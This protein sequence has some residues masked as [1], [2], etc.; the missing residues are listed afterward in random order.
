[1]ETLAAESRYLENQVAYARP[2]FLVL[3]L[4]ALVEVMP[5]RGDQLYLAFLIIY[6]FCALV[7]AFVASTD[8]LPALRL[9]PLADVVLLAAYFGLMPPVMSVIFLYLFVCFSSA[10]FWELKQTVILAG[11]TSL[12]LLLRVILV[13]QEQWPTLLAWPAV[14]VGTFGAGV[15]LGFLADRQRRHAR[16]TQFLSQLTGLLDV[17]QGLSE[18]LR[19]LLSALAAAFRSERA[20]LVFLDPDLERLFVWTAH[21]DEVERISPESH[22][23]QRADAFLVDCPELTVCWNSLEGTGEG[24]AWDRRDG[25]RLAEIPRIPGISRRELGIHA[26]AAATFDFG[27]KPGGRL[28]LIN[29]DSSLGPHDLRWFERIAA[30]LSAPLENLYLL[31]HLRARVI[32]AER[33]RIS[34]D[35]HDGILQTL[36]GSII[37]LDVMRKNLPP[38]SPLAGDL[39]QLENTL[40][41][42]NGELRKLVMDLR[43]LRVARADMVDLIRGHCER[44]RQEAKIEVDCLLEE[45]DLRVPDRVCRELF[46]ICR[47]ALNNVKKHA[48]ATHVVIKLWQDEA[49]V[50]LVIDDNGHGFSFAGSFSSEEL[51]RLRIGPISIKERARGIGGRLTVE[52]T[53]GHGARILVEVPIN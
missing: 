15:G 44:F 17:E 9:P 35:L 25:R 8:R 10:I 40:R 20:S 50:H 5:V 53:P 34:H 26:L 42:E 33:S 6:L 30:S 2:I 7:L 43:P 22:P 28:L 23:P 12:G 51:N 3:A 46:Q 11:V 16:E 41:R 29:P 36:L 32:D 27:G 48:Q 37:Q 39:A 38:K 24:F 4:V 19:R 47:E 13:S 45:L 52:S 49:S 31:R 14:G 1:M 21:R 18:S